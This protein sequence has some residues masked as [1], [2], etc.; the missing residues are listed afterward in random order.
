MAATLDIDLY[1]DLVCPWCLIG[2]R[3][4]DQAVLRFE[5]LEP[6]VAVNLR[7]HSVQLL[8]D[9]PPQGWDFQT[10]YLKRLGGAEPLRQRQAQ[11]NAAAAGVGLQIDFSGIPRMPNTLLA[12]QLLAFAATPLSGPAFATLLE[13]LFAAHFHEGRNL[14]D[15]ATLLDIATDMG[16]EHAALQAWWDRGAG[17]PVAMDVP[18]VPFY[19]FNQRLA[20]SGAQPPDALQY[21]MQRA[22][23]EAR[24]AAQPTDDAQ[25]FAKAR[26]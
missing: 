4:L 9:T 26:P 6:G 17:Q 2:K 1:I 10:F 3:Q 22:C 23:A 13:R 25:P 24:T 18:G 8:P 11:V 15:K 21:A 19:V 16:L 14:G 20:L 5:A 12:H 7:W